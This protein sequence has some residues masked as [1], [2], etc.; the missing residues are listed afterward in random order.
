MHANWMH[1]SFVGMLVCVCVCSAIKKM[2]S[3]FRILGFHFGCSESICKRKHQHSLEWTRASEQNSNAAV[4]RRMFYFEI[5][6]CGIQDFNSILRFI[7]YY[8]HQVIGLLTDVS[9]SCTNAF[10]MAFSFFLSSIPIYS[11][12]DAMLCHAMHVCVNIEWWSSHSAIYF[13]CI[14]NLISEKIFS[15]FVSGIMVVCGDCR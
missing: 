6:N 7:W 4:A 2:K 1:E 8:I 13:R 15:N 9:E 10:S 3:I 12:T 11:C 14:P 5:S